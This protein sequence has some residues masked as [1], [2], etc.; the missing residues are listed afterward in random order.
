MQI[1][2]KKKQSVINNKDAKTIEDL[3]FELAELAN[4]IMDD[5]K[6][7]GEPISRNE[8]LI[9]AWSKLPNRN[10]NN[11]AEDIIDHAITI[12]AMTNTST[13]EI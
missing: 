5:Y 1:L 12:L 13:H 11:F 4:G 2:P 9:F 10:S 7:R 8:A 6:T 3:A